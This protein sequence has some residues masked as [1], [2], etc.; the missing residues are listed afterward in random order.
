MGIEKLRFRNATMPLTVTITRSMYYILIF[1][2]NTLTFYFYLILILILLENRYSG[3]CRMVQK[4]VNILM[5]MEPKDPFR[6]EMTD[7]LL[8]KL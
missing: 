7:M 6:I 8:E 2:F 3:L 4:L 5:K 1:F